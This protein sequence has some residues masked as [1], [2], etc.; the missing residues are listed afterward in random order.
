MHFLFVPITQGDQTDTLSPFCLSGW[1]MHT[2]IYIYILIKCCP[3]LTKNVHSL[4]INVC[5]L[6]TKK[7]YQYNFVTYEVEASCCCEWITLSAINNGLTCGLWN[8][9]SQNQQNRCRGN[10]ATRTCQCHLHCS[11]CF[12]SWTV[13]LVIANA[14]WLRQQHWP[15]GVSRL[16]S[17]S[18]DWGKNATITTTG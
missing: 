10:Q 11:G 6:I 16:E 13:F 4:T 1:H 12:L 9:E 3:V 8:G 14:V 15:L 17:Y 7:T 18:S 5:E 2:H